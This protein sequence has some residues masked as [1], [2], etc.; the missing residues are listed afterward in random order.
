V[1]VFIA[2]L[3]AACSIPFILSLKEHDRPPTAPPDPGKAL[4][5]IYREKEYRGSLRGMYV[6]ANDKR[7]GGVSN[8]TYFIHELAPGTHVF[9]VEDRLG[10]HPSRALTLEAGKRY[11]LRTELKMGVWDAQPYL[12]IVHDAEGQAAIKDLTYA[13]LNE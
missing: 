5:V 13:T 9:A 3:V 1:V 6:T 10:K 12:T 11:Y 8:G 4:V 7:I 2:Q